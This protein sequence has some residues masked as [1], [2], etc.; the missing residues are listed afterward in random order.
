METYT[1][2][3]LWAFEIRQTTFCLGSRHHH[4]DCGLQMVFQVLV[5]SISLF[6]LTSIALLIY[7][8]FLNLICLVFDY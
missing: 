8:H 5:L 6:F 3:L 2:E 1:S 4:P 7:S